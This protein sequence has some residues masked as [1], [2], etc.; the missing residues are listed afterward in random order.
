MSS[1]ADPLL[2]HLLQTQ[3]LDANQTAAIRGWAAERAA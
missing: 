1:P 2:L 3:L